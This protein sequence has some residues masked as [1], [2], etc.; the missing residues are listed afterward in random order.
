MNLAIDLYRAL[1]ALICACYLAPLV[2]GLQRTFND[3]STLEM[4]CPHEGL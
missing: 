3:L 2:V 1:C 4:R